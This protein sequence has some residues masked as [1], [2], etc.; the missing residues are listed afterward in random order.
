MRRKLLEILEPYDNWFNDVTEEM[1]EEA[2]EVLY[3]FYKEF[4]K[5]KPSN[6]YEKRDILH[7]SYIKHLVSIKKAFMEKKYMRVC[8][9]LRSLIYYEPF[10]QRRTYFNILNLLKENL[11]IEVD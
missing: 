3:V 6:R 4:A 1:N 9:E 10:L 2:R 7:T 8:N 11:G 5:L